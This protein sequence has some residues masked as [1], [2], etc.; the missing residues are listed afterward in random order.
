[1]LTYICANV[2]FCVLVFLFFFFFWSSCI[3]S[4]CCTC[5]CFCRLYQ[6]HFKQDWI[7]LWTDAPVNISVLQDK[8]I[9]KDWEEAAW[10]AVWSS[11]TWRT[12]TCYLL[13]LLHFWLDSFYFFYSMKLFASTSS[14]ARAHEGEVLCTRHP[15]TLRRWHALLWDQAI[16]LQGRTGSLLSGED[17]SS[18]WQDELDN[19]RKKKKKKKKTGKDW[20]ED[21]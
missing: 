14:G 3:W 21:G 15:V 2:Y 4:T 9:G 5:I 13:F 20:R 12:R 7:L 16:V 8:I 11:G 10:Q 18:L 1:M 6:N 17:W 19:L